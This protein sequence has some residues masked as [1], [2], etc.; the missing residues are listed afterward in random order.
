MEITLPAELKSGR[1]KLE[2]KAVNTA[3]QHQ[4]TNYTPITVTGITAVLNS[5]TLKN[6]YNEDEPIT[7]KSEIETAGA[8]ENGM[9]QARIIRYTKSKGY[10]EESPGEYISYN[11]IENGYISGKILYL[12]TDKGVL[13]HEIDS[14]AVKVLYSFDTNPG[15]NSRD[16]MVSTTGEIW[17]ATA[18][19]GVWKQT[20][21]GNWEQYTTANGLANNWTENIIEVN[22]TTGT[23]IWVATEG[24]ISVNRG[25][26]WNNYTTADGLPT[27]RIYKLIRD[28]SGAV[29]ASTGGGVVKFNGTVFEGVNAPY[30][31]ANV[32]DN[33]TAAADGN[34]WTAVWKEQDYRLYRYQPGSHQWNE[35]KLLDLYPTPFESIIIYDMG[36]INGE[37]WL[38]TYLRDAQGN[39]INGLLVKSGAFETYT[40]NEIPG[41]AGLDITSI[42]PGSGND[43][44]AY[45]TGEMGYITHKNGTWRHKT[46]EIDSHRLPGTI[47]SMEK[48]KNG[49]LWAGTEYGLSRYDVNSQQWTNYSTTP[50]NELIWEVL[51]VA[52]DGQNSVYGYSPYIS[53]PNGG[54]IKID[55]ETG[56]MEIIP[57]PGKD[58]RT[59]PTAITAWRWI[60]MGRIWYGYLYLNYYEQEGRTG[61]MA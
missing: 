52:T 20:N 15:F 9:L 50:G 27:N 21:E 14:G 45:F 8:I 31:N 40:E 42:I 16:L 11:M 55:I 34:V 49:N 10:E 5:Y 12:V 60:P 23:E 28:G 32:R 33:M 56:A 30:A 35:W 1:Y 58:S 39:Y 3:T 25:G 57:F 43:E 19:K 46:L 2:Q 53:Y 59:T 44:T 26:Q 48:D 47:Y 38:S 36:T 17:I 54:I 29:W 22:S 24:G 51:Q 37:M 13:Q 41:L 4:S 7:G 61:P 18:G 6:S